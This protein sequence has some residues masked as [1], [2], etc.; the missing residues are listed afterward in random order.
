MLVYLVR[1]TTCQSLVLKITGLPEGWDSGQV[2]V[3][4]WARVRLGEFHVAQRTQGVHTSQSD[5]GSSP[6]FGMSH[7]CDFEEVM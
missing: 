4:Q 5:S 6:S 2:T 1:C 3:G 7:L